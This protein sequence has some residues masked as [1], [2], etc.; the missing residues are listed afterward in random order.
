MIYTSLKT[1]QEYEIVPVK[2]KRQNW[3]DNGQPFWKELTQYRILKDGNMVQFTYDVSKISETISFYE[4]P[5]K[6]ISS[7]F[8]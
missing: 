3:D 7:R 1:N 8:D 5:G 6:D 2:E 4:N